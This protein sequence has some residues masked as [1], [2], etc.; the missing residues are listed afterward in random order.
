[1]AA[2]QHY[3]A[4]GQRYARIGRPAWRAD[5]Q[6][7][8]LTVNKDP[9]GTVWI[10]YRGPDGEDRTAQAIHLESAIAAG[11]VVPVINGPVARC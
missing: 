6:L 2:L 10:T 4:A 1:M 5:H 9:F 11:E 8:I 7:T 3:F